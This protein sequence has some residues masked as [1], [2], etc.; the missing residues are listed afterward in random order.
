[1]I[2]EKQ[3]HLPLFAEL[4]GESHLLWKG[5][6]VSQNEPG[7]LVRLSCVILRQPVFIMYGIIANHAQVM[8]PVLQRR[9]D[10]TFIGQELDSLIESL[11]PLFRRFISSGE[12]QRSA[13]HCPCSIP[14]VL[15]YR[16]I[17]L[18]KSTSY[19]PRKMLRNKTLSSIREKNQR[20]RHLPQIAH[21]PLRI[22]SRNRKLKG[23]TQW[24]MASIT[25]KKSAPMTCFSRHLSL[26]HESESH[27]LSS[28]MRAIMRQGN[29]HV[30]S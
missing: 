24:P 26:A 17:C 20:M 21:L 10:S 29:S 5:V 13:I 4:L 2:R 14:R 12:F 6:K 9:S 19:A 27:F 11:I 3:P 16:D 23:H 8:G 7:Q 1:M 18:L 15:K 25:Q 28:A 22:S 30:Y